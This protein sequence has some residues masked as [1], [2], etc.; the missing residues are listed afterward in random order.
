[1]TR[2]VVD[3]EH[4]QTLAAQLRRHAADVSS[5]SDQLNGIVNG[6]S[7]EEAK[8]VNIAG[9]WEHARTLARSLA[10]QAEEQASLLG[11]KARNLREADENA[12]VQIASAFENFQSIMSQAPAG[13]QMGA[14]TP[15]V[16]Q[17]LVGR[18][19]AL[20]GPEGVA[21]PVAS[22][23][24]LAAIAGVAAVTTR[25]LADKGP[26]EARESRQPTGTPLPLGI[27]RVEQLA[28]KGGDGAI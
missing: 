21:L 13:W 28:A 2:I 10:Q 20:G 6:L 27:A 26:R 12:A 9:E 23:A 11:L 14:Y 4:L 15:P 7:P 5:T 18:V 8:Q 24:G 16:P 17:D 22:V 1:M 19:S 25:R 3:P